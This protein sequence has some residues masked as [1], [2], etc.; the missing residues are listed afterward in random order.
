MAMDVY[1]ACMSTKD[2]TIRIQSS[3]RDKEFQVI[4]VYFFFFFSLARS[5]IHLILSVFACSHVD[6]MSSLK[7][8][9]H[10]ICAHKK[11]LMHL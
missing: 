1:M 2:R 7:I 4:S 10:L 3:Q 9:F 11:S 8:A 5:F 6:V